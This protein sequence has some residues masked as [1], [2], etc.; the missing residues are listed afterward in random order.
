MTV[1]G[2]DLHFIQ[3]CSAF[4]EQ[5]D[6]LYNGK[7]VGYIRLRWGNMY[8][9]CP[10]VGGELVY[11]AQ[12]EEGF[13]DFHTDEEREYYLGCARNAIT[14]WCNR[15]NIQPDLGDNDG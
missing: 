5:Y 1:T 2:K 15:N 12:P 4:P 3:T 7:T 13:G 9:E 14:N 10:D 6:V 8:V 11:E